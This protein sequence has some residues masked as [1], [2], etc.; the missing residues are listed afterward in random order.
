MAISHGKDES[1]AVKLDRAYGTEAS[2]NIGWYGVAI[3]PHLQ[4]YS[5]CSYHLS[6]QG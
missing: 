4:S 2:L 5:F 6:I 3:L 1:I